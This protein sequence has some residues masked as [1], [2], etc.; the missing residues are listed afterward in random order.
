MSKCCLVTTQQPFQLKMSSAL[1]ETNTLSMNILML[2]HL[3]YSQHI[4]MSSQSETLDRNGETANTV[5]QSC[6][7][8]LEHT[9]YRTTRH[10]T[11]YTTD[12]IYFL[13]NR[14]RNRSILS[15]VKLQ[16]TVNFLWFMCFHI[17]Y[18]N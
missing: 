11:H 8:C 14:F 16:H 9:M 3:N 6:L 4:C 18:A 12:A 1:F 7:L 17:S 5:V 2:P 10:A 13:E 15:C